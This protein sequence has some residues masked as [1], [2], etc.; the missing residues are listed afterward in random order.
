MSLGEQRR[1][2]ES[3]IPTDLS[4]NKYTRRDQ[5]GL[6]TWAHQDVWSRYSLENQGIPGE[7]GAVIA[8]QDWLDGPQAARAL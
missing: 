5:I 1:R 8:G 6:K 3:F 2:F 7:N 4:G